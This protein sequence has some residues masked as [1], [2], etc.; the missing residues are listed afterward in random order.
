M[1][2]NFQLKT[3]G[4]VCKDLKTPYHRNVSDM[5][6]FMALYST[7]YSTTEPHFF[8]TFLFHIISMVLHIDIYGR[9]RFTPPP[10][11]PFSDNNNQV[12]II[13]STIILAQ[14]KRERKNRKIEKS[15]FKREVESN[16][17]PPK[18]AMN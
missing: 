18:D 3:L 9:A 11:P 16:P 4:S 2:A 13:F 17:G 15:R 8:H 14:T 5:V 1:F 7:I 12:L 10:P 6:Q